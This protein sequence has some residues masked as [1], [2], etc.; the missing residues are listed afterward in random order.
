MVFI[1][2]VIGSFVPLLNLIGGIVL[3]VLFNLC[4]L[5]E[6]LEFRGPKWM[7]KNIK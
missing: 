3:I 7:R 6:A 5:D 2:W 1:F 4:Y